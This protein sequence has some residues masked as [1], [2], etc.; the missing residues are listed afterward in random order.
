MD[1]QC[2]QKG[3]TSPSRTAWVLQYSATTISQRFEVVMEGR[4]GAL[5]RA[6]GKASWLFFYSRYCHD[7]AS[8]HTTGIKGR[9][10]PGQTTC[11]AGGASGALSQTLGLFQEKV[12]LLIKNSSHALG[13]DWQSAYHAQKERATA[14]IEILEATVKVIRL[15]L[16][17]L[18]KKKSILTPHGVKK[19]QE[20][21][22]IIKGYRKLLLTFALGAK[23]AASLSSTFAT[24]SF[25]PL[26]G[27]NACSTQDA[28]G[29][30]DLTVLGK[31]ETGRHPALPTDRG[32]HPQNGHL[33]AQGGA[34]E[35]PGPRNTFA[36]CPP[37]N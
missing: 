1:G 3:K 37:Q 5:T 13:F 29:F 35:S 20:S 12:L 25:L 33:T 28:P 32:A 4:K 23:A 6:E 30:T 21:S 18:K 31:P 8:H 14:S 19:R 34:G 15:P 7:T 22:R 16:P 17:W 24:T 26:L 11:S 10:A 2:I 9:K 27:Y 36:L